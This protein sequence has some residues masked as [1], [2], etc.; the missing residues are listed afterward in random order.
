MFAMHG[1]DALQ[2][3]TNRSMAFTLAG[4]LAVG[5]V[6][7]AGYSIFMYTRFLNKHHASKPKRT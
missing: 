1:T 6:M 2:D 7:I 5:W 3:P 4:G